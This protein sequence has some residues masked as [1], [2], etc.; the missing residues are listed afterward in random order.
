MTAVAG[1]GLRVGASVGTLTG[2]EVGGSGLVEDFGEDV[3][4]GAGVGAACVGVSGP[5]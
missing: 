1:V 4:V 5:G 2:V 3:F